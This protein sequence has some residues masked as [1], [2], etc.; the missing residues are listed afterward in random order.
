MAINS[1]RKN[2]NGTSITSTPKHLFRDFRYCRLA[3]HP[4]AHADEDRDTFSASEVADAATGFFGA[5]TEGVAKVIEGIFSD[6]GHPN[7]YIAGEEI[8]GAFVVGLRYG[9]G[10]LAIKN[11]GTS[12]T[13]WQGPSVGF[14]VG[15]NASKTFV[16][17]YGLTEQADI[18]KRFAGMEGTFYY[19]AGLGVNYPGDGDITLVPIRTGV[20]LRQGANIGYL[21]YNES[22]SWLPF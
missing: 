14:D 13:F 21:H 16:L 10:D 19:V 6:L 15:G 12:K 20:S 9:K 5:T 22:H 7:A 17:V 2:L 3:D 11:G 1:Q 18:Y 4:P 8:S